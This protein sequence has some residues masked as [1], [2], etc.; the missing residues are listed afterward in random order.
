VPALLQTPALYS[1]SSRSTLLQEQGSFLL[2][3]QLYQPSPPVLS[4]KACHAAHCAAGSFEELPVHA[5]GGGGVGGGVGGAGVGGV[6]GAVGG[7]GFVQSAS[8]TSVSG[9]VAL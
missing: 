9:E 8:V 4:W 5:V 6:G 7:V 2:L 3:E 1:S